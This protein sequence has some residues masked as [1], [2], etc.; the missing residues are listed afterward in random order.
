MRILSAKAFLST[1]KSLST[2]SAKWRFR[3]LLLHD[4]DHSEANEFVD[5]IYCIYCFHLTSVHHVFFRTG[6]MCAERHK[7]RESLLWS[8]ASC[9]LL[10]RD[11]AQCL[12]QHC[13][14]RPFW[15]KPDG[16]FSASYRVFVP[17]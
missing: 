16:H 15:I 13:Q 12:S 6:V 2:P 4:P 1:A 10:C 17:I 11:D 3:C 7:R 5:K 14:A 9:Q 8:V